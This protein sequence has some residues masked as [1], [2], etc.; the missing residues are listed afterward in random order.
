[1]PNL[2]KA[3]SSGVILDQKNEAVGKDG[4]SLRKWTKLNKEKK[5]NTQI[6][7]QTL[8]EIIVGQKRKIN[9]CKETK[10]TKKGAKKVCTGNKRYLSSSLGLCELQKNPKFVS[11]EEKE[12]DMGLAA[13]GF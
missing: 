8:A 1:M 12:N 6:L 10:A 4:P 3:Q 2:T 13:A 7:T 11:L 9:Q 5:P